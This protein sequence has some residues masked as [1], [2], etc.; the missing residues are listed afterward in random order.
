MTYTKSTKL[1]EGTLKTW[2]LLETG[3]K[4][5]V[6]SSGTTTN[7]SKKMQVVSLND[8]YRHSNC[9]FL[10]DSRKNDT[11]NF[12]DNASAE[13]LNKIDNTLFY[14]LHLSIQVWMKV[15]MRY[16]REE[17]R[18]GEIRTRVHHYQFVG[19]KNGKKTDSR[20][21]Y[22]FDLKVNLNCCLFKWPKSNRVC[23]V[24][25]IDLIQVSQLTKIHDTSLGIKN[26]RCGPSVA[27]YTAGN[28]LIPAPHHERF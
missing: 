4:K 5:C 10:R 12:F 26:P 28:Y 1:V 23:K 20:L 8:K 21:K 13:R 17:P 15:C 7:D 27:S 16:W 22:G 3:D 9:P 24:E 2:T 11:K 14:V 6:A 25:S 19:Q 18:R